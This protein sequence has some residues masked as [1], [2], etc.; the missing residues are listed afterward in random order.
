MALRAAVAALDPT[1]HQVIYIANPA[2]GTRGLYVTIVRALGAQPR[3]LKAELMAQASDLLAA[4]TAERH[5]RVVVIC[6]ESHLLQPDQLEELRLLTNSEM[7]SASPF[8]AILAGQPTLNRQLRMGMFAA[9]D[10]R[11]TVRYQMK[12]MTPDETAGYIRHHLEQAGRT[13]E[14]FTDEAVAQ[15]HQAARGKPRTVNNICTAAL[16]A[17]AGAGKNLA[18]HASARAAIAEVTATD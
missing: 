12:G 4:E 18:G 5:R 8:A 7:D 11:I 3:Y 14:L 1:R 2:F 9:L 10:Q 13:A 15:I 16:I 17:T 6:D